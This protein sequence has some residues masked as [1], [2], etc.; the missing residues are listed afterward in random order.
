VLEAFAPRRGRAGFAL[1]AVD[2]DDLIV[3][4]P[5]ADGTA[6]NGVDYESAAGTL[7][8]NPGETAKTVTVLI[9]GDTSFEPNETFFL[10]L[11][12]P[13]NATIGDAQGQGTITND[14]AAPVVP[15][16]LIGDV[17]IAEGN[18]GSSLATFTVTLSPSSASQVKVDYANANGTATAGSDYVATNGTL[19]FDPGDT[20]KSFTVTINGDTLFEPNETFLVNLSNATGGAAIGDGQGEV[21]K[22]ADF[23]A[24]LAERLGQ[25]VDLD[26]GGAHAAAGLSI[27]A[28]RYCA[29]RR[30]QSSAADGT[31]SMF[32]TPWPAV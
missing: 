4:P 25:P 5:E 6:A 18:S 24:F 13:V 27:R 20:S 16:L 22:G 26:L 2:D 10:N 1:I 8:F 9:N 31:S 29:I 15:A 17:S 28:S 21:G 3:A 12:S 23:L 32:P 7:T 11:T 30:R 19:T 14:E